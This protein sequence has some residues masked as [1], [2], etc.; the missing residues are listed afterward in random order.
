VRVSHFLLQDFQGLP[1][2]AFPQLLLL[3]GRQVRVAQRVDDAVALDHTVGTYHL[4][5]GND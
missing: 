4:G 2:D 3:L 1:E 5:D